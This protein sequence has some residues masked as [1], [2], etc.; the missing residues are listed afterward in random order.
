MAKRQIGDQAWNRVLKSS[1]N[2]YNQKRE[3]PD[4]KGI[5]EQEIADRTGYTL[6][7]VNKVFTKANKTFYKG[8]QLNGLQYWHMRDLEKN[9]E[10]VNESF[11]AEEIVLHDVKKIIIYR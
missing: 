8:I 3:E 9:Q 4:F 10:K 2:L 11:K 1:R 7:H 6:A 5:T